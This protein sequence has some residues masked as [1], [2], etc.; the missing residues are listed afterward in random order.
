M[1]E[2]FTNSRSPKGLFEIT[3]KGKKKAIKKARKKIFKN[4][5]GDIIKELLRLSHKNENGLYNDLIFRYP[6]AK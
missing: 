3:K 5:E 1:S 2:C 6:E 4:T